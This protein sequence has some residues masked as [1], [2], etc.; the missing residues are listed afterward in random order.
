MVF[1]Y[2]NKDNYPE[3]EYK[4]ALKNYYQLYVEYLNENPDT[5]TLNSAKVTL[6]KLTKENEYIVELASEVEN[7]KVN[8]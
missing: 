1:L 4:R 3:N 2:E 8:I 6:E 7:L 5:S